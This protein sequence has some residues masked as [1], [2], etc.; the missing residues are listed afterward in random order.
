MGWSLRSI[1][2]THQ[3][4]TNCSTTVPAIVVF[5]K[6][7]SIGKEMSM[8]VGKAESPIADGSPCDWSQFRCKLRYQI[9]RSTSGNARPEDD[10][11]GQTIPNRRRQRRQHQHEYI[12]GMNRS[13]CPH[14]RYQKESKREEKGRS[15]RD[16][17]ASA[18]HQHDRGEA[19]Q[20]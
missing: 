9:S 10:E 5:G 4:C 1:I 17:I 11:T 7:E 18:V 16:S 12:I 19:T 13:E 6:K 3:R 2:T 20:G 8:S 14:P 15:K